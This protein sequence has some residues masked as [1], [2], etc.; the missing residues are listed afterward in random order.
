MQMWTM[1]KI[2][3]EAISTVPRR[4]FNRQA[5]PEPVRGIIGKEEGRSGS[6][7]QRPIFPKVIISQ[8]SRSIKSYEWLWGG[9]GK[10]THA[11]AQRRVNSQSPIMHAINNRLV[12]NC[13]L[14]ILSHCFPSKYVAFNIIHC[15]SMTQSKGRP[16]G[17]VINYNTR[18]CALVEGGF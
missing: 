18:S 17:E 10:H 2:A 6:S 5:Y 13:T 14:N 3:T 7:A 9:G 16:R 12:I 1:T 15:K 8:R 11:R 4:T